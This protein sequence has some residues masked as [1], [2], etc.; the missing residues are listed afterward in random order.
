MPLTGEI[1]FLNAPTWGAFA[2]EFTATIVD[3]S[4]KDQTL[5]KYDHKYFYFLFLLWLKHR[6]EG[7]LA[8]SHNDQTL[9]VKTFA[10]S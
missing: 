5:Q 10:H 7:E 6:L 1:H 2:A 3:V 9:P 8:A 4:Q